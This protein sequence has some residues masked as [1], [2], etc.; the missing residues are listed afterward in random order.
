MTQ[1]RETII[2]KFLNGETAGGIFKCLKHV[3]VKRDFIY[4]TIKRYKE[5]SSLKDRKRSGR[6]RSI[7]TKNVIHRV[8]ER[9]RRNPERSIRKLAADL[10]ISN[11]S[12]HNILKM[13]L[14]LTAYKKRKVHGITETTKTKR[15][16]RVSS[17]LAWH[18]GDEFVFSDE[19]LFVLQDSHNS[20]NDRIWSISISSISEEQKNVKRF[21]GAASV[22]VWGAISKRGKLPLLFIDKGVKINARYYQT[23]VL[24]KNLLPNLKNMFGDA[25]YVFQQDGAPSHT[26]NTVQTWCRENLVD[27]LNKNEWPPSSPDLNPLDYF[28]WSYMLSKLNNNKIKTLDQFKRVIIKIWNEIPMEYVRAA[29]DG[30]EKRLKLVKREKGGVIPKHFL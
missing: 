30:F 8:R 15:M 21:Q 11:G 14:G 4:R 12:A 7:R 16:E 13:D 3:G 23:E 19:K 6:P 17:I 20:Q 1:V 10:Q 27:F 26:A 18:A 22:M 28:I 24:E 9:I 5:T 29:C 2:N 25:Y